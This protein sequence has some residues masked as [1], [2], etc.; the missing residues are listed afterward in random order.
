MLE[1]ARGRRGRAHHGVGVG[2]DVGQ[3]GAR[4]VR[5]R[6]PRRAADLAR[7]DQDRRLRRRR[8]DAALTR[9][10]VRA[11]GTAART[12]G[13]VA[14]AAYARRAARARPAAPAARAWARAGARCAGRGRRAS[15]SCR[16][17]SPPERHGPSACSVSS[18]GGLA[19]SVSH[20]SWWTSWKYQARRPRR[21]VERHD[22]VGVEVRAGTRRAVEVGRGI[23]DAEDRSGPAQGRRPGSSRPRRRRGDSCRCWARC[24]PPG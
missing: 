8:E 5:D 21:G 20:R 7:R 1:A 24:S 15:R 3:A 4:A 19:G 23:G 12:A 2:G 18:T 10:R 17:G 6:R 13:S 22:A 11:P 14:P 16:P 9:D